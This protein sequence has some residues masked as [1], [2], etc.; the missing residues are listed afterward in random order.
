VTEPLSAYE[1][2]DRPA[3]LPFLVPQ[4]ALK[5]DSIVEEMY[6][7]ENDAA[8]A[9]LLSRSKGFVTLGP[10]NTIYGVA[11]FHQLHCISALRYGYVAAKRGKLDVL[12]HGIATEEHF[13]HCLTYLMQD[14]VCRADTTLEDTYSV[15]HNGVHDVATGGEGVV[16]RCRDW[17]AVREYM[18]ENFES[19]LQAGLV[20][21]N[22]TTVHLVPSLNHPPSGGTHMHA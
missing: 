5:T 9:S 12:D 1:G 4:A 11:M 7:I 10:K 3:E 8:W 15:V 21:A 2:A 18:D 22:G 17:T 14:A 20:F 16:H 19:R 13:T 6:G